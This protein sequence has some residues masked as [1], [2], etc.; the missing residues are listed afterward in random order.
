[1]TDEEWADKRAAK[2]LKKAAMIQA[3]RDRRFARAEAK[4]LRQADDLED[5]LDESHECPECDKRYKSEDGLR[6]HLESKHTAV[7][8]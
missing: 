8:G 2:G 7:G 5:E 4:E 1:M 3:Q 6:R